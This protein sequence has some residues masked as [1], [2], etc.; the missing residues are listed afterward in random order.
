M[1]IPA[2]R[3]AATLHL[4]AGVHRAEQF[5]G[6]M[7]GNHA[8]DVIV[9]HDDL[10]D[11]AVPLFGEHAD[12]SRAAADAHAFL[13]LTVDDRRLARLN[14]HAGPAVDIQLDSL[15]IAQVEQRLARDPAFLLSAVSQMIDAAQRQHLRAVFARRHM[16]N[17]LALHANGC[18]FR[19]QMAIGIDLYLDAAV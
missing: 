1:E 16:A 8:G 14:D 2:G 10:I 7:L 18:A 11:F 5:A 17:R 9:D 15:S 4:D 12:R 19:A 3:R 13:S 6:L